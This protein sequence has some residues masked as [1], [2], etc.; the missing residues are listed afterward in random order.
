M[1]ASAK[2]HRAGS[3]EAA[4]MRATRAQA[5][6]AA[7]DIDRA[8]VVEGVLNARAARARAFP[9]GAR[10]GEQRR[11][12]IIAPTQVLGEHGAVKAGVEHRARTI[13]DAP[14]PRTARI[15]VQGN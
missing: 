10:V 6:R 2:L 1:R 14:R 8:A 3:V 12:A 7:V 15:G 11:T 4:R 9:E 5:Q 13:N